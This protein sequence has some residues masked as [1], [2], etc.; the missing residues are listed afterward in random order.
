MKKAKAKIKVGTFVHIVEKKY[1]NCKYDGVVT[2]SFS[3]MIQIYGDGWREKFGFQEFA[4]DEVI[5]KEVDKDKVR[6]LFDQSIREIEQQKMKAEIKFHEQ[7]RFLE[8]ALEKRKQ[9]FGDSK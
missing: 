5:V 6:F 9:Y 3:D 7:K 1:R 8:E 2:E 4:L